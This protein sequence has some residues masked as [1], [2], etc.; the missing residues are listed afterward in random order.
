VNNFLSRISAG[1]LRSFLMLTMVLGFAGLAWSQAETGQITGTVA[2]PSGGVVSNVT[3]TIRNAGT[4]AV[5]LET[6]DSKGYYAA[7]NLQPAEYVVTVEVAGFQRQQKQVTLAVGGTVGLNFTLTLGSSSTTVEVSAAAASEINTETPTIQTNITQQMVTELPSLTRNPYDFVVAS[8]S[9]SEQG[10]LGDRGVGV[11]INGGRDSGTNVLLDGAANNDEFTA[12]VGQQVPLDSVQEYSVMTSNWTAQYGRATAGVVNLVTKSGSNDLHGSLYEFNRVSDLASNTYFNNSNGLP[13]PHYTRNDFGGSVGGAIKK[14]KLFFFANPEWNRTR[15]QSNNLGLI[16]DPAFIAASDPNTVA[17]FAAAP[18]LRSNAT[19]GPAFNAFQ[20]GVLNSAS[21]PTSICPS[22][23]STV[24]CYPGTSPLMDQ[25]S[26]QSPGDSGAG[27]PT[28]A[29]NIVGRIDYTL[30]DKT[31][32]YVRYGIQNEVDF[33]GFVGTSPFQGFDS[34]QNIRNQNILISLTKVFSP[35]WVS[36]SKVVFNRLNLLQP[37]GTAP[38]GPTLYL[39]SPNTTSFLTTPTV[40]SLPV[41]FP[42]YNQ[43]TPGNAIPFG[44]PQNFYEAYQDLSYTHGANTWR[45]GGSYVFLQDN[46]SFGAYEEATELLNTTG[47]SLAGFQNLLGGQL[48][49]FQAAVDPQGKF[50]CTET[51]GVPNITPQCSVTLPAA[52]PNF[53]RS[54][55][56]NELAAYGMDEWKVNRRVTVTLGL[57]WEYFG[58][59]HN[60]DQNLDSNFYLGGG[61]SIFQQIANGNVS[62]AKQSPVG[63]LWEPDYKDFGPRLG[64]AWDVF[65]DGKTS[66]R[67]GYGI[68]YE[69]N[70]GNVTFNMI[71]NPPAYAVVSIFGG[72]NPVPGSGGFVPVTPNNFGPLGGASGIVPLPPVELRNVQQNIRNAYTHQYSLSIQRELASNFSVSVDYSGA[73]GARQYDI[74]NINEQGDGPV[75]LGTPCE[76]APYTTFNTNFGQPGDTCAARL[77]QT[78]QYTNIN[79]R[80]DGGSSSY[81]SLNFNATLR[82]PSFFGH[83]SN[84]TFISNYTWAHTIDDLSSTFSEGPLDFNLGYVAPFSPGIDRGNS[85][86]DVRNRVAIVAVWNIPF[87]SETHGI[88][89]QVLDGWEF[90][91]IFTAESGTPFTIFDCTN[92]FTSCPRLMTTAPPQRTGSSSN[93]LGADTF[94][95]IDLAN[96]HAVSTYVNPIVGV[97]DFGPFPNSFSDPNG[98]MTGRDQFRGPGFWNINTGIYKNFRLTERFRLQFRGELYNA[99]NHANLVLNTGNFLFAGAPSAPGQSFVSGQKGA[100][101]NSNRNVQLGLKLAF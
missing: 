13:K 96:V 49:Q 65:G 68:S 87:A 50:P 90:A 81:N 28:N 64:F 60:K 71:Q 94:D 19:I 67:G 7:T 66:L 79:R 15:S 30:S 36:Q 45:F 17:T 77:V 93:N 84:L 32:L 86:L 74:A 20:L 61:G 22:A 59:Q 26:Y 97:S 43:F 80:G 10:G 48:F 16:A 35:R 46:R 53:S 29:Y 18:P 8:G 57:R 47:S 73:K 27:A 75:F 14:D 23:P 72:S 3:V 55:H 85:E 63:S 92:A 95:Y 52:P 42:G 88:V 9:V 98:K 69:R 40:G 58:V 83:K 89:K 21:G 101:N 11:A 4:G 99:F 31:S 41:A 51:N 38:V 39:D 5:R 34:G 62:I 91:P 24:A 70:F 33:A 56:Y 2:D 1:M 76:G 82:N 37:L 44:G 12:S 78:G 100:A 6:S 54:N 25:Y